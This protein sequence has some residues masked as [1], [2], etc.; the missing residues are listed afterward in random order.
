[1]QKKVSFK[2]SKGDKLAGFLSLVSE[3]KNSPTMVLCHGFSSN[4]DS[5]NNVKMRDRLNNVGI[6]TFGFDFFGHGAS[7]GDFVEITV[8]EAVDD[9][10]QAIKYIKSQGFKRV[11]LHGTSFGGM[12]SI[13]AA[14][15]TDDLF[16]LTLKS[17]VS[18]ITPDR[19]YAIGAA[20]ID[21]YSA[22]S[23]ITAPTLIVHGDRDENVPVEQ[24][25][26]LAQSI[27]N[28]KF[29]IIKGADHRYTNPVHSQLVLETITKFI[30]QHAVAN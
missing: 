16:V 15:Q 23:K 18:A 30:S 22:A 10:L 8:P 21:V 24:S 27:S 17:P 9:A 2:N 25:I 11:G 1:M 19:P 5:E 29:E 20:K 13:L 12:A 6:S 3:D 4:K 14:S 7:D 28:S 26:K